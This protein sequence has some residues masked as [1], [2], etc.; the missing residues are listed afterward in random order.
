MK[1]ENCRQRK[2]VGRCVWLCSV[3][4]L[5][6]PVHESQAADAGHWMTG[7]LAQTARTEV[8]G[9]VYVVS[10][11]PR[12]GGS[13][14]SLNEIFIP[15]SPSRLTHSKPFGRTPSVY[16]GSVMTMLA[17]M[18]EAG[19][20][21]PEAAPEANQL[22]H[23]LIQSQS[24]FLK[25]PDHVVREWLSS[26]LAEKFGE[27]RVAELTGCF[28]SAGWTT[29]ALEA[30]VDS[31]IHQS[32]REGSRWVEVLSGYGMMVEDWALLE[33]MFV[34][35]REQLLAQ[36]KNVHAVFATHRAAMPGG[37]CTP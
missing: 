16:I 7:A 30:L 6:A 37:Q 36:G 21:P 20:L 35:A 13:Y 28:V 2:Q 14:S 4:L 3:L 22:I 19:V 34:Q 33:R 29:E 12:P 18:D 23:A 5:I 8:G 32:I 27:K 15:P 10:G 26:A 9:H 31:S 25:S 17:V 11:G 1:L 24:V